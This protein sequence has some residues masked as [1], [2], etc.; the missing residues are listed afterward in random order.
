MLRDAPLDAAL[1]AFAAV[2]AAHGC[3]ERTAVERRPLAAALGHV[4]AEP[5]VARADVPAVAV[6]AMDGIA[7]RA[8]ETRLGRLARG[9]YVPVDTGMPLPAGCDAVVMLEDVETDADGGVRISRALE[10]GVHVREPAETFAAGDVLVAAGRRLGPG[11]LALAAAG[12]H[13]EL[14]VHARPRVAILPTGDEIVPAGEPVPP[15]GA[16]DSNSP[17]L[18]A[19]AALAGAAPEVLDGCPDDPGAVRRRVAAACE[20]ADCVL[21]VAGSSRGRRDHTAAVVTELGELAVAGLA[22]RP[23]HPVLLGVVAHTPVIGVPGYPLSAALT[24]EL[25]VAPL[26]AGLQGAAWRRQRV[27]V[28]LTAPVGARPDAE[29]VVPVRLD[30]ALQAEPLARKGAAL[31]SLA[32]AD[33]LLRVPRGDVPLPAGARVEVELLR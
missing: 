26:V 10:P 3:P 7:V 21:V 31:A 27:P 6:A 11:E 19:Q 8:A 12:G 14:A 13:A 24:F 5:V 33:G 32:A 16:S 15:G 30:D 2:R 9:A 1:A 22:L 18:A 4:A 25:V 29:C 20:H 23:C 17:M 28:V